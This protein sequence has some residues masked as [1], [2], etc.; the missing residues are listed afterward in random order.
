ME[1]M[2]RM[3]VYMRIEEKAAL[4]ALARSEQRTLPGTARW[5]VVE[6]LR[7]LGLYS[8]DIDEA[9]KRDVIEE[10]RAQLAASGDSGAGEGGDGESDAE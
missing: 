6:G 7:R 8:P 3:V 4:R 9:V 10:I 5:L 1:N 2:E